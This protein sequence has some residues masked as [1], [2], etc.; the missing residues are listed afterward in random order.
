MDNNMK[1]KTIK[2]LEAE[3]YS[4]EQDVKALNARLHDKENQKDDMRVDRDKALQAE[5]KTR[6]QF[7]DLKQRLLSTETENARL[8]GYMSRVHEDDIVRDGLV[9]IED[10]QGKRLVPKR[11][12]PMQSNSYTN[13]EQFQSPSINSMLYGTEKKTHW[14]SY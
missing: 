2:Q 10:R 5:K 11:P 9:E 8:N 4:L 13:Y 12:N 6:A 1:R 3:I 14:T 7:D